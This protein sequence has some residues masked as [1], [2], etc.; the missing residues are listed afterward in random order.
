MHDLRFIRENIAEA[1]QGFLNRNETTDLSDLMHYD[2]RRREIIKEVEVLK[3][4][5]NEVTHSIAQKKKAK[6]DAEELI[7]EMRT[8]GESIKTMDDELK[9]VEDKIHEILIWLPNLPHSSTPVGPDEN[10]NIE[11]RKWGDISPYDFEVIEHLD[12]GE[13]LDILDFKRGSK[14]TGHGFPLYKGAGARLERALINFM[15]DL[16]TT[17]HGFTEVFP[18]F[19]VNRESAY[20]TG[21]IPKL[22]EDMYHS[23]HEDLFLIPTAEVPVTNIFRNEILN[24]EQLPVYYTAYSACFRREAGAYGKDTRGFHRVHQFNKVEMVKF[25]LPETSYDELETLVICA[26]KI[27]QMLEIPYRVLE[28]CSGDLGFSAAKCY[29]LEVW[30]RASNKYL[31]VSS[32]SNFE[33]FQARRTNIR[34]R[35]EKGSK[36][37][38]IHTLNGS[39]LATSR[40]MVAL[41]EHH[42]TDEGTVVVPQVLRKYMGGM[43]IIK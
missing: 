40:L 31:E 29:D 35:R 15:L 28:L 7:L 32:C 13:N 22:E 17:E 10:S 2:E 11:V 33:D 30:S 38:F 27:L 5:R 25:V 6:E 3:H 41:L 20:G 14:I 36:V 21:Q 12:I 8:V 18:P 42:Q 24:S 39:G 9:D 26:E 1:R 19:L 16:H 43:D 23:Q 4:K 34:F 37:E